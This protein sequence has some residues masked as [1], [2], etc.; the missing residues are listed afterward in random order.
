MKK[1]NK[2]KKRFTLLPSETSFSFQQVKWTTLVKVM[3]FHNL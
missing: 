2:N 1:E 3:N